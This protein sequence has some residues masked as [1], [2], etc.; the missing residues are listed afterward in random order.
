MIAVDA[1]SGANNT[2]QSRRGSD[3]NKTKFNRLAS[4]PYQ[5]VSRVIGCTRRGIWRRPNC[6]IT[7]DWRT[8]VRCA[9]FERNLT[10]RNSDRYQ[11]VSKMS[12]ARCSALL[13]SGAPPFRKRCP[14]AH[15]RCTSNRGPHPSAMAERTSV[16]RRKSLDDVFSDEA[17]LETFAGRLAR[18]PLGVSASADADCAKR[19][20]QRTGRYRVLKAP[21]ND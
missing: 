6:A 1:P 21:E 18:R 16:R 17:G 7:S 14:E 5:T 8:P 13:T 9:E 20:K 3:Q 15:D 19:Q 12:A 10:K 4:H 2:Q 11:P